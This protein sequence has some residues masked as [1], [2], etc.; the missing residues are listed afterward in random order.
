MQST[1]QTGWYI[2]SKFNLKIKTFTNNWQVEPTV[3]GQAGK[4]L[5]LAS[6][7]SPTFHC[8]RAAAAAAALLAPFLR[9]G[10]I[11]GNF[12]RYS[13]IKENDVNRTEKP[14]SA[15]CQNRPEIEQLGTNWN[16]ATKFAGIEARKNMEK[17]KGKKAVRTTESDETLISVCLWKE[18]ISEAERYEFG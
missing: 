13:Q 6:T 12:R 16:L 7:R 5:T 3:A 14:N 11:R 1:A 15:L 8:R 10:A 9:L 4:P 2:K 17:S 18:K